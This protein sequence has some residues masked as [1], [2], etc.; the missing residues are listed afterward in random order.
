MINVND[1]SEYLDTL[2]PF[3]GNVFSWRD[4]QKEAIIDMVQALDQYQDEVIDSSQLLELSAPTASGK[5]VILWA[6]AK[7]AIHFEL[8]DRVVI[9]TP[10]RELV[11]QYRKEKGWF[12]VIDSSGNIKGPG[13]VLGRANYVCSLD[14]EC[15]A[16]SCTCKSPGERKKHPEC[17]NCAYEKAKTLFKEAKIGLTTMAYYFV[18]YSPMEEREGIVIDESS[19]LEGNLLER[20]ALKIPS[21]AKYDS[22]DLNKTEEMQKMIDDYL[23]GLVTDLKELNEELA[24]L[25]DTK[26]STA[27]KNLAKKIRWYDSEI[28]K[29][30]S[31]KNFLEHE[32]KYYVS[33]EIKISPRDARQR[34]QENEN[35]P[36][37]IR[38]FKLLYGKT[39]F[40]KYLSTHEKR[41]EISKV[42]SRKHELEA[43]GQYEEAKALKAIKNKLNFI[44]LA[45]GTPTTHLLANDFNIVRMSHPIPVDRRACI[46]MPVGS[47]AMKSRY[48]TIPKIA[49]SIAELHEKYGKGRHTI[50]HCHSYDIAA[51]I[52]D[53]LFDKTNSN[54]IIQRKEKVESVSREMYKNKWIATPDSIF[55]S[56]AW[57]EG[58]D[59]KGPEYPLNII[60]KVPFAYYGDGW[61]VL[62]DKCDGG[63]YNTTTAAV[64]L[65]QAA[66]RTTRDPTDNSSTFILDSDFLWWKNKNA[67][68]LESWFKESLQRV[69][70]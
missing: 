12:D 13:I 16:D 43:S 20:Y 38:K 2:H 11:N 49:Q 3:G 61:V 70:A 64:E 68:Y 25:A 42:V 4:G 59:L 56:V 1:I 63:Q 33:K 48:S 36:T 47:M 69:T 22:Y 30:G 52:G 19:G 18:G 15:M 23:P 9:T 10:Q 31:I 17:G 66:G 58:L 14:P 29:C 53:L 24:S 6:F 46:I 54:I 35:A 32:D 39:L 57:A 7:A 34:G 65:Q 45:S 55:M 62:R 44:V 27:K 60:V 8:L 51:Q 40:N 50:V 41:A 28:S 5:S 37:M 26:D 21:I 67:G